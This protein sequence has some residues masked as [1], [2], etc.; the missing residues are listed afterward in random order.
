[1]SYPVPL[2][3]KNAIRKAGAAISEGTSQSIDFDKVD[4]WRAS[5]G[6]VINTFQAWLRKHI[7]NKKINVEFAQR[8]KRQKTVFGKL[9]RRNSD[10]DPLISDVSTMHDF[11]EIC[12][13]VGDGRHQAAF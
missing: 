6:Y 9:R 1:M 5:H 10:G 13:K 11:A 7:A 3:S 4:N 12:P 8:L 2:F